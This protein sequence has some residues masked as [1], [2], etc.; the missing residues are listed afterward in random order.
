MRPNCSTHSLPSQPIAPVR[1]GCSSHAIPSR[2]SVTAGTITSCAT[3]AKAII[4]IHKEPPFAKLRRRYFTLTLGNCVK[5][6]GLRGGVSS[7]EHHRGDLFAPCRR[8]ALGLTRCPSVAHGSHNVLANRLNHSPGPEP[9]SPTQA[10]RCPG[11][12]PGQD[13]QER[14]P[15]RPLPPLSRLGDAE[16]PLS[17]SRRRFDGAEVAR[18]QGARRGRDGRG[19]A[20]VG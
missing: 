19:T 1:E 4:A 6:H 16:R 20:Q 7:S 12:E 5:L 14:R 2:R 10:L 13:R 18:G 3:Y 17:R 11:Q 15:R 9:A 8:G